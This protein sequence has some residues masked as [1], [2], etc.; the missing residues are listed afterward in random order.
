MYLSVLSSPQP[1]PSVRGLGQV[2]RRA[3]IIPRIIPIPAIG[4]GFGGFG[5]A[6]IQTC[7]SYL[8]S[9]LAAFPAPQEV[10]DLLPESLDIVYITP[11][12]TTP[13]EAAQNVYSLASSYCT[14]AGFQTTFGGTP[15]SDCADGGQSAAAAAYSDWLAYYN[16]LPSG[17]W[18]AAAAAGGSPAQLTAAVSQVQSAAMGFSSSTT[19][20]ASTPAVL[21]TPVVSTSAVLENLSSP[22]DSFMVGD[23]FQLTLTGSP[24][25]TVTETGS[26]QNGA[27]MGGYSPGSTDG[28]GTLVIMGTF[29]QSDIGNWTET[30]QV[31]SGP[32]A[33]ISFSIAAAPTASAPATGSSAVQTTPAQST[34]AQTALVQTVATPV[35]SLPSI[36]LP[37]W[38]TSDVAGI[39]VWGWAAGALVLLMIIPRG[40]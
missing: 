19:P 24:N 35:V 3:R 8:A 14:E 33:Q 25:S 20:A 9:I 4:R 5:Q 38:L 12:I 18:T 15:P 23:Q 10:L 27:S 36:A 11:G 31:G 37:N 6:T 17:V 2:R 32:S 21:T 16:S 30:W 7:A 34:P 13:A 1:T 29:G 28:T 39:P 26:T 22:G 40:R